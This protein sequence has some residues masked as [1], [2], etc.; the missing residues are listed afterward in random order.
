MCT[1]T[2]DY[3]IHNHNIYINISKVHDDLLEI[4]KEAFQMKLK[5]EIIFPPMQDYAQTWVEK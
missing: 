5:Q 1:W 2:I 3:V 4:K